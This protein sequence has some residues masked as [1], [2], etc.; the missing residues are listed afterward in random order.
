MSTLGPLISSITSAV[1]FT[2]ERIFG[3]EVTFAPSTT[4]TAANETVEP[5]APSM[6][7][8]TTVSPTATFSWRQPA[9]T[10]AYT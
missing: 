2:P 7:S 8:T 1:T 9:F 3:S 5:A 6:R 4:N 10:I